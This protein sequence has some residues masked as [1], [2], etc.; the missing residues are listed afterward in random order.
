MEVRL[1]GHS[2]LPELLV[3]HSCANPPN[4]APLLRQAVHTTTAW[5]STLPLSLT[6]AR[7]LTAAAMPTMPTP[8]TVTLL[9]GTLAG[10][11]T[12]LIS[13]SLTVAMVFCEERRRDADQSRPEGAQRRVL[14]GGATCHSGVYVRQLQAR[15]PCPQGSFPGPRHPHTLRG[16]GS[17]CRPSLLPAR[18]E[19]GSPRH[20]TPP[21]PSQEGET[22]SALPGP[23]HSPLG[24]QVVTSL[25]SGTER[26]KPAGPQGV[27]W[28]FP[29][30]FPR[31]RGRAGP[32]G[33][34]GRRAA[35][36]P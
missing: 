11:A 30:S 13:L 2:S 31:A 28:D 21:A 35:G 20:R 27:G 16:R 3:I 18:A 5:E 1:A 17:G 32:Q 23:G 33:S 29:N 15:C 19:R 22:P 24:T 7:M 4:V 14:N 9:L 34:Q 12:G 8:T 6:L 25:G 26:H 10:S 36:A